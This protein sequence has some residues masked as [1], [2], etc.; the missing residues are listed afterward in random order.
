MCVYISE[1]LI[2]IMYILQMAMK[3]FEARGPH[4]FGYEGSE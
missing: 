2:D 3:I 1:V 4:V